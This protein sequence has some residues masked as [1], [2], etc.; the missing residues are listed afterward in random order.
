MTTDTA[1]IA[2]VDAACED[3]QC[4]LPTATKSALDSTATSAVIP[5]RLRGLPWQHLADATG[6]PVDAKTVLT[7]PLTL[8]LFSAEWCPPCRAI[9]PT[10][11]QLYNA[12]KNTDV[13]VVYVSL[14]RTWD[15]YR[16]RA[17]LPYLRFSWDAVKDLPRAAD[18]PEGN[19]NP[20]VHAT[21]ASLHAFSK[22]SIPTIV[23]V[24][25]RT[26]DVLET[27]AESFLRDEKTDAEIAE[28]V[29]TW[30]QGKSIA[31]P[32]AAIAE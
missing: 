8:Y 13:D 11:K 31:V 3:G 16:V 17:Q 22:N 24:D 25:A 1:P 19:D 9:S 21:R 2:P 28:L 14:D 18:Q 4:A 6:A 29:S 12:H 20:F 30:L 7:K 23:V 26:G 27:S 5:E 15:Q 10:I 32:A